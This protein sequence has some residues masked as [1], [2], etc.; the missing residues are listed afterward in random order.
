MRTG[1]GHMVIDHAV[2]ALR[3]M[4]AAR[5]ERLSALA[6]REEALA[7]QAEVRG[8]IAA[9]FAPPPALFAPPALAPLAARVTGTVER[10]GHRIEKVMLESVPGCLVTGNLYIPAPLERPA[11]GALVACG[12]SLPGK[13]SGYVQS[14]AQRLVHAGLVVLV[15]DPLNQGERVQYFDIPGSEE[16]AERPTLAHNMMGKQA[17]LVGYDMPSWFTWDATRALDYL[18]S[19]PEVDPAHVGMT[20]CS[21]GGTMTTWM[22]G[23]D[24]RLTMAAPS[25]FVTTFLSNLENEI[26]ADAEQYPR[27]ALAAGLEHADF[28]IA[29]APQPL[30]LLGQRYCFFDRRGV[31]EA[32]G[33]VERFYRLLGAPEGRVAYHEGLYPHGIWRSDE[34][35]LARFFARHAGLDEAGE[36]PAPDPLPEEAL[37]ATPAGNVIAAGGTPVY[38]LVGRR[39]RALA[40]TRPV[41][42]GDALRAT[43]RRLLGLPEEIG[44]PHFRNLRPLRTDVATY[45]RCAVETEG[46]VRAILHKRLTRPERAHSLEVERVVRLYLPHRSVEEDLAGAPLARSLQ[47]EGILYALDVRGLGETLPDDGLD[48]WHHYNTD[49]MLHGHGLM[50]GRPYL[51][52]RVYDVLATIHLL[53]GEGAEEVELIGRGQGALLALFA[54]LLAENVTRVTLANAPASY[55]EWAATAIVE[56]PAANV[57]PGALEHLD[58]PD[59]LRALG[60]RVVVVDPWGP[61]MRPR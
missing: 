52:R 59:C 9:L 18:L 35:V 7:Y 39:A 41:L 49:Y 30:I 42:E 46:P 54:A 12:H 50:F 19:R 24:Q 1:Y 15:F 31:Q 58:L 57:L 27:G 34:D 14:T 56:W 5:Q 48:F 38:E 47:E 28:L 11:P 8:K 23:L 45:A 13:A 3:E 43:L 2:E 33:E 20:G 21:G 51:G 4:R 36:A 6:T 10:P 55:E 37:Y 32:Y 53:A 40:E 22:W 60:E 44:V 29:R 26:P 25:C 17:E 16:T 61:R